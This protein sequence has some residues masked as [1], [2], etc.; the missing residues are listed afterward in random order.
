MDKANNTPVLIGSV[1]T[2]T[3]DVAMTASV[4]DSTWLNVY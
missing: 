4:D 1:G 2:A 3:A